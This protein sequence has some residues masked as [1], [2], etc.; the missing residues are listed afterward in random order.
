METEETTIE[1]KTGSREK[2]R[3]QET[4]EFNENENIPKLTGHNE[5]GSKR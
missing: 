2:L 1:K 4:I 5:S 3:K